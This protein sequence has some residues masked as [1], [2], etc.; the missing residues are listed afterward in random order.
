M[1]ME[2]KKVP[3]KNLKPIPCDCKKCTNWLGSKKGCRLKLQSQIKDGKCRHFGTYAT[4][5]YT[6]TKEEKTAIREHNR[7]VDA[8][9][10][11]ST[12]IPV[13]K[14]ATLQKICEGNYITMDYLRRCKTRFRPGNAR[15]EIECIRDNPL[16]IKMK[17]MKGP[18]KTYI[19]EE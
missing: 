5:G 17:G 15:Y 10:P 3:G 9:R 16:T 12:E 1:P 14:L 13:V 2:L 19:I 6:L 18:R 4:S 7:A 11:D 8:A